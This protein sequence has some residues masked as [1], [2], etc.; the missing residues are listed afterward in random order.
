VS[1]R[2][3]VGNL[4]VGLLAL[5]GWA[6]AR[7]ELPGAKAPSGPAGP[8]DPGRVKTV[9]GANVHVS[10]AKAGIQH[11]ESIVAAHPTNP[12]CLFIASMYGPGVVGYH[13]GDRGET[14]HLSFEGQGDSKQVLADPAAAFG[15]DGSLY[16]ARASVPLTS[17]KPTEPKLGDSDVG[18]LEFTRSFDGGKTWG[19]S[20][21][22]PQFT[23][24]P[25]L[26]VDCTKGKYRGPSLSSCHS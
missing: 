25:W 16:F 24:R 3:V 23:D 6:S 8:A 1:R 10:K 18:G 4:V 9:V 5:G 11:T 12:A 19:P 20:N 21:R 26:A 2:Y 22:I 7:Q 17:N 15:P 14:W 13:S